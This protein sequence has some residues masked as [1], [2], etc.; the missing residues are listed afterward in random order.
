MKKR[1]ADREVKIVAA[2]FE[3]RILS[4]HYLNPNI[5]F[6]E[7]TQTWIKDYAEKQLRIKTVEGYK[8]MIERINQGIGH[9]SIAKLLPKHIKQFIQNIH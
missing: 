5:T 9:I 3:K 4:G 8:P 2:D 6:E 7:Y 1:E